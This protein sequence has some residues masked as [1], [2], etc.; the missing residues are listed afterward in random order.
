M[1]ETSSRA[2]EAGTGS[3]ALVSACGPGSG[4]VGYILFVFLGT[5]PFCEKEPP[6]GYNQ[7]CVLWQNFT[8]F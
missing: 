7:I 6:S 5:G 4:L 8:Y 3:E 1:E 2:E